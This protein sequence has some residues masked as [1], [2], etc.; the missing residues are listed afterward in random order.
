MP[1][2]AQGHFLDTRK[3]RHLIG[4]HASLCVSHIIVILTH[5]E[6]LPQ[7][8]MLSG[9]FVNAFVSVLRLE[10]WMMPCVLLSQ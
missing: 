4:E 1:L 9:L 10:C 8:T 5:R 2:V 3:G 7:P 6:P